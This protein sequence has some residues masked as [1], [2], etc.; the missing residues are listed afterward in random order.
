MSFDYN[1]EGGQHGQTPWTARLIREAGQ[2][3]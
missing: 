2:G 3:A 1:R